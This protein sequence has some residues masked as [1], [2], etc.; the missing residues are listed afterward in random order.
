MA[1]ATIAKAPTNNTDANF[2]LWG[3]AI[4]DQLVTS[5]SLV[6]DSGDLDWTTITTPAAINTAQGYEIWKSNDAGGGLSNIYFKI[7]Y[8]SGNNA[9]NPSIWLTVGFAS[10][11]AGIITG[12]KTARTQII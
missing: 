7:E 10:D 6:P 12:I 9:A 5:W 2:R 8:G 3:K 1:S 4:S 11:G